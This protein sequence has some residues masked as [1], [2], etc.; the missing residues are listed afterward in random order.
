MAGTNLPRIGVIVCQCGAEIGPHL[1]I[2]ELLQQVASLPGVVFSGA[3]P[4]PCSKEGQFRVRQAILAHRLERLVVAGCTPRLIEKLFR[5]VAATAGL[6]PSYVSIA[7]IRE[8]CLYVHPDEPGPVRS[9]AFDLIAMS[10]SRLATIRPF[11]SYSSEI[12]PAAMVIGSDLSGLTISLAL[13]DNGIDVTLVEI[14]GRFAGSPLPLDQQS[15]ALLHGQMV[16]AQQHP[17][18]RYLTAAQLTSVSGV[19]GNYQITVRHDGQDTLYDMGAVVISGRQQP[20][21][22][23]Q[24]FT[25]SPAKSGPYLSQLASLFHLPQDQDGY[26]VEPRLRLYP[27]MVVDDGVF[28]LGFAHQPQDIEAMTLQAY[29]TCGRVLSFLRKESI[30]KEAPVAEI[31]PGLCTGCGNCVQ[32]CPTQCIKMNPRRSELSL[33]SVDWTRCIG[34][35]NCLVA[36]SVKAIGLPEWDDLTM[37]GQISA[38]FGNGPD[39]GSM[40]NG[41]QASPRIVVLACDWN[42]YA[43]ADLAGRRQIAYPAGVRL[44][45]LNCSARFD[46]N[47]ALWALLNGADGVALG[48]CGWGECHYG[49]G[50]SWAKERLVNLKQQLADHGLDPRRVRLF[51]LPGDDGER[52][53]LE[54]A[55]F[56]EEL[57]LIRD[58]SKVLAR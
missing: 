4:Y 7:N 34:C 56:A 11:R 28:A 52:F 43:A 36:C 18:I 30:H 58:R 47:M 14:A 16:K 32:V 10:V 25:T 5:T 23:G 37:L 24:D 33:A 27:H 21:H 41:S 19:P 20:F 49:L 26:L 39:P 2:E 29:I 35:G 38:A 51:M 3:E 22:S 50:N 1:A 15:G 55:E 31:D 46:P 53:A 45:R 54:M 42:A 57:K 6:H 12:T 44:I 9:K 48:A 8:Q 40:A 13:A 17:R